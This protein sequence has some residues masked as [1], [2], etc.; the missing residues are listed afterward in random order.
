MKGKQSRTCGSCCIC[1]LNLGLLNITRVAL[2]AT[3]NKH[4]PGV[5]VKCV[6]GLGF[7]AIMLRHAEVD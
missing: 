1:C 3:K 4:F 2:D 5:R 6:P 7:L